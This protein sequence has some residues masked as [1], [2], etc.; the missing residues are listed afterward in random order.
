MPGV[1]LLSVEDAAR[2]AAEATGDGV[3]GILLFGR[4]LVKDELGSGAWSTDGAVARAIRAI[5]SRS[6]ETVVFTDVCLC[7]YTTDGH[8]GVVEGGT[9][10]N[11]RTLPLLARTAVAHAAAGADLVAPSAMMDHQVSAIR[12]ALDDAGHGGTG[13]LA[14]SA[15]FASGFY[16]PFR[17]AADSTPAVGD[18]RGYQ[19][20]PRNA[21]EAL[22]EIALDIEEGADLV[23]V[24]PALPYLDVLARARDR[25]DVPL[26]A[27]QVSGE[28][29]MVKAAAAQG[30]L[31][32]A[33]AVR[34]SLTAIRR[35]GA[36]LIITYFAREAARGATAGR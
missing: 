10:D 24:K 8:C 20:D 30:W 17:E 34:E 23:M 13:I 4:P 3:A 12:R 27:Y 5:K 9:V 35:A 22:R 32:E 21:R 2:L 36:D 33:T 16:G 18:R 15:K 29:S 26:V 14:Y 6:P 7:A 25:F 11:D 19:L 31:D 28:Y 1:A